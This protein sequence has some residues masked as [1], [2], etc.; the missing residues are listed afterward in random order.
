MRLDMGEPFGL[1]ASFGMDS[2]G[3]GLETSFDEVH[4]LV[5]TPLAGCS[6]MFMH[7][8]SPSLG[9]NHVIPNPLEHSHVSTLCSPLS[10]SSP[11]LDLDVPNDISTICDFNVDVGHDNNMFNMLGGN[12]ENFKSLGSLCGYDAALDQYCIDLEDMPRKI[13]WNTIFYF[14][15]DFSMAL[16]L[17]G[18]ILFFV[19]IC[20]FSHCQACEPHAVAFDKLLRALIASDWI[21]WV[22]KT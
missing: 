3:C 12:V 14:S 2:A 6:D 4:N 5:D 19:L 8:G 13:M 7:E 15:F 10:L 17:R 22:L 18:L 20:M 21:S 11:E 16:T 9:S 1:G